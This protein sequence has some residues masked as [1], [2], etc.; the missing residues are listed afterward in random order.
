MAEDRMTDNS[1]MKL[2]H[3]VDQLEY[4]A[5]QDHLEPTHYIKVM[6]ETRF[7]RALI[8][9]LEKRETSSVLSTTILGIVT[10]LV[11]KPNLTNN[12]LMA[13]SNTIAKHL[14]EDLVRRTARRR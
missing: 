6:D 8:E 1:L 7:I 5:E 13:F 11:N 9:A 3:I 10:V 12:L 2:H 4:A 14:M